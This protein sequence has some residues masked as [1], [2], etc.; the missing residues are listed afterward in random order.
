VERKAAEKAVEI[1]KVARGLHG[2]YWLWLD[3]PEGWHPKQQ[4]GCLTETRRI[5]LN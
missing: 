1:W 4:H 3:G 5:Q 2:S